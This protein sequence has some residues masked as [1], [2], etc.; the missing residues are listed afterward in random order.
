MLFV[1]VVLAVS[2]CI[3][4]GTPTTTTTTDSQAVK[5][6]QITASQWVFEPNTITV[7]QGDAVRLLIK[8]IDVTHGFNIPDYGIDEELTPG[9]VTIVEF[10]ADKPGEFT[11]FCSI[12]CGIGHA[13]MNG[14][15]IVSP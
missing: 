2:G 14:K 12:F 10:V 8:S 11:F 3:N 6:F 1:A 5:E 9:N 7:K 13:G 15:L 4:G